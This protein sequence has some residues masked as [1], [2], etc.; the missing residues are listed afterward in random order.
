MYT[1]N[2]SSLGFISGSF[3]NAVEQMTY[4]T[5]FL[6]RRLFSLSTIFPRSFAFDLFFLKHF[7]PK[8]FYLSAGDITIL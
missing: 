6:R 2:L 5:C 1:N 4:K 7:L 3:E 8:Y